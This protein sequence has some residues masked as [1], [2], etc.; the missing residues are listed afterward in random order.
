MPNLAING[1]EPVRTTPFPEYV[2]I[3]EEE[4]QAV[5][6]VMD[7]TVLSKFLATWSDDFYGGRAVQ[8]LEREWEA[9]FKVKH[10]VSV[11]SATSGLYA[12]VGAAG[13]GPGDERFGDRPGQREVVRHGAHPGQVV[14]EDR[15]VEGRGAVP[16]AV[17]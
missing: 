4:K 15:A 2:T 5:M 6:E 14:G 8:Q 7:S 10:A 13:V 9:H 17:P 1:G 12:A 16:V 11:N 3:G